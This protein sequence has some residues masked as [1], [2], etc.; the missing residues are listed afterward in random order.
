MRLRYGLKNVVVASSP[1]MAEEFLKIQDTVFASRPE[2]AA[3]KYTGYDYKNMTW[4]P[5]GPFWKL[6]RRVYLMELFSPKRLESFEHI[7]VDERRN[8]FSGIF[9]KRGEGH[10]H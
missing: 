7:R 8:F 9:A 5:Y 2:I 10:G 1:K 4:A 6:A 3:G